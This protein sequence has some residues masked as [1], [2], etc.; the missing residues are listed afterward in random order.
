[1]VKL[2]ICITLIALP[3]SSYSQSLTPA[4]QIDEF[5]QAMAGPDFDQAIDQLFRQNEE[6][7]FNNFDLAQWKEKLKTEGK[8]MLFNRG[9][10]LGMEMIKEEIYSPSL[11]RMVYVQKFERGFMF[12]Q[13]YF[14]KPLDHWVIAQFEIETDLTKSMKQMDF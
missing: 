3:F 8:Q 12:W 9:K 1:M 10:H 14:Y 6:T 7:R 4:E 5:S 2:L 13:F 11:K